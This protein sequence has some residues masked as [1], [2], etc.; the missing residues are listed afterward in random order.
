MAPR[1]AQEAIRRTIAFLRFEGY[2]YS[3]HRLASGGMSLVCPPESVTPALDAVGQETVSSYGSHRESVAF[4][5]SSDDWSE[6]EGQKVATQE[7]FVWP[8]QT[9]NIAQT[10]HSDQDRPLGCHKSWVYWN[11]L[12]VALGQLCDGR[13]YSH[14]EYDGYSHD[15]GGEPGR[16]GER[17]NLPEAGPTKRMITHTS[18]RR[19]GRTLENY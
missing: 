10:P 6:T 4:H 12:G 11:W 16:D 14:L 18:S 17:T 13:I 15:V 9:R 7:K 8:H 5:Q 1:E 3:G 2:F 19:I